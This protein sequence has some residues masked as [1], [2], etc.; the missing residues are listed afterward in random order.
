MTVLTRRDA[1][2]A[3]ALA[4]LAAAMPVWAQDKA[5]T[6]DA[7]G[8]AWDL[9]DIYPSDAAWDAARKQA[10]AAVPGMAKYKGTLGD[11]RRC[12]GRGAGRAIRSRPHDRAH[13][14]LYQPEGRCRPARRRQSGEAGAGDR[15]LHRVRRGDLLDRARDCSRSA[16]PR[17][18]ASSPPNDDAQEAVR[19]LSSPISL[20]QA[21]HTLSPEGENLLAG[22]VGALFGAGRH[23]RAAASPRTF[24]GRRSR[25]RPASRCGSTIRAIRSIATPP[26]RADRKAVFDAFFGE[27]GKFQSSLGAAY[28]SHVKADIFTQEGAQIPH[29]AGD[30]PVRQQHSRGGLSHAGQRN[31]QRACRS[32]TAI[33]SCAASC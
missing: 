6:T 23:S 12:A 3:A 21:P 7:T 17:S 32:C 5:T 31:Q 26:N 10:L 22:T 14:H 28:L 2:G 1:L 11:Q 24:R 29:L 20:R 33:S 4:S 27:Y 30:V 13:L 19:L 15:S 16:R 8:A 25:C 9:S 18:T